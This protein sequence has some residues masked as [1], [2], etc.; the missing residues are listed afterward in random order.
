M[1]RLLELYKK[2]KP[3]IKNLDGIIEFHANINHNFLSVKN[4]YL[5]SIIYG[6]IISQVKFYVNSM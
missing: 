2:L 4:G 6:L 3:Q 1:A 5:L